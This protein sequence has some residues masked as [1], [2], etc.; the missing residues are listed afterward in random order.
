[1]IRRSQSLVQGLKIEE[2]L[3]SPQLQRSIRDNVQ[4]ILSYLD[5][6]LVWHSMPSYELAILSLELIKKQI[7][8]LATG[9]NANTNDLGPDY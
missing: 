9:E 1:M 6:Q 2:F 3:I 8:A 5:I 4:S 7:D